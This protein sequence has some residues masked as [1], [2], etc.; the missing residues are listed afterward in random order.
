[1]NLPGI[2]DRFFEKRVPRHSLGTLDM[3]LAVLAL[4][5]V[6]AVAGC[7]LGY[8]TLTPIT[9]LVLQVENGAPD[10]IEVKLIQENPSVT[11]SSDS[12]DTVASPSETVIR[13]QSGAST[14]GRITCTEKITVVVTNVNGDSLNLSG[15][16]TGT[17][18]FDGGSIGL[19]GERFLLYGE[20]FSCSDAVVIQLTTSQDGRITIVGA[21][22]TLPDS[23]VTGGPVAADDDVD[24]GDDGDDG[25]DDDGGVVDDV[26]DEPSEELTV[27]VANGTESTVQVNFATGDGNLTSGDSSA[28]VD[29]FDV[30]IP[31]F[32]S[33]TGPAD[34]ALEY[35]V[36]ASHLEATGTT[37]VVGGTDLFSSDGN[38]TFHAVVLTGD[39]TGTEGFDSN[40]IA[41]QRGRLLQLGEHY[42]CGDSVTV[43]I[44]ATN[45]QLK[46]D[47]EGVIELDE[48]GNPVINYNVGNGSI[49]VTGG[50]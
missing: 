35:I 40:T 38:V 14:S 24:D 47:D 9:E 42:A 5:S 4:L 18:G 32:T 22:D 7:G 25:D 39:G 41:V 8:I 49:I 30:R 16:G 29:E 27:I 2:Y 48:F 12:G 6:M 46:R 11:Q 20:H 31:P 44:T 26:G 1:M 10:T 28:I 3:P 36:A 19:T 13:V 43:N 50:F 45:N 34:C 15:D 37:F 33:T 17:P 23:V 21:T